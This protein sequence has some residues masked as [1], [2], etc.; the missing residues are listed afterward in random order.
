MISNTKGQTI[1]IFSDS[2]LYGKA[3]YTR[4]I[5]DYLMSCEIIDKQSD[6]FSDI[7]YQVKVRQVSPVLLKVLNSNNVVLAIGKKP[8]P[9]PFKVFRAV[10]VREANDKQTKKVF[11]DCTDLIKL[12]GGVYKCKNIAVLLSYLITAMT[13][14]LYH[15]LNDKVIRN[16][17]LVQS[18]TEAFVD[19]MLYILGYLRVPVTYADNKEKMSY[20]LA[21]YYQRCILCKDDMTAISQMCKKVSKLDPKKC[22]YLDMIFYP[23]YD[24]KKYVD[25]NEFIIEFARIFL[26]QN[27]NSKDSNRLN[28]DVLVQ[29]WMYA[30]GPGT[31]L[32]LELFPP[33]ASIL[34]DCYVGAFVNQQNTIEKIV[35]SNVAEFTNTLLN[36]GSDNA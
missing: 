32:G 29:R 35:G 30:F 5:F 7:A 8:M 25:I 31:Y 1:K 2:Y 22:E 20:A 21:M 24:G 11:I 9:R 13:Y 28:V 15:D 34:T 17:T 27:V 26:N 4:E 3:N 6:A 12:D 18:G 36:L 33:F 16:S 10:N 19:L 23:F 14:V